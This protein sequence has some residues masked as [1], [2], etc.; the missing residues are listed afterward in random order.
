M[1]K[2]QKELIKAGRKDLAQEYYLKISKS[3]AKTLYKNDWLE[4]KELK[5]PNT[6]INGYVFSHEKRCKGKIVSILPF[7]KV[8]GKTQF[9]LRK[10]PVP[11]WEEMNFLTVS[12]TGG[13]ENEDPRE[14]ALHELKEEGGYEID[15]SQLIDLGTSYGTKSSD[16]VYHLYSADLSKIPRGDAEGDGSEIEDQSYCEWKDSIDESVDPFTYVCFRKMK[17]Y[18]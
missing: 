9:L 18:L 15:D 14:T 2:I 10:E 7:R 1:D 11:C 4:L 6:P 17:D 3:F 12:I 8:D 16:T 13:V 5:I